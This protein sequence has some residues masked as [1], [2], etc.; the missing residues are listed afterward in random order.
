MTARRGVRGALG[1]LATAAALLF[2]GLPVRPAVVHGQAPVGHANRPAVA[3]GRHDKSALLSKLP[4]LPPQAVGAVLRRKM[5]PNRIGSDGATGDGALQAGAPA[6]AEVPTGLQ[7]FEGIGN[8]NA[9]LPPDTTGD[10]GL[11]HYVQMVNL[12][13]AMWDRNGTLV[14]GPVDIR[15]LWQG[16]GGPCQTRNDGDPIVQYDHLADRW[17][18]SQFALPN[19]PNGPFYQCIAV[20]ETGDPTGAYYRYE[21]QISNTKLNDY[22]KF[23]VWPDGYYMSI[24]QYT[25]NIVF[26]NWA[27]QGAVV[28]E[29]EAMLQGL[30]ARRVYFDLAGVD[31]NLGG[32]L[33]ADLDGPTLPAAGAANLFCQIDDNGWGYSGDQLQCWRF[34]T[35]WTNPLSST[36]TFDAAHPTAAFDADMCNYSR[37][38]IPQPGGTNVDAI[39]DRLMYRLQYRNFGTHETLVA[40]HTVDATGTDRGGVRW[41]ELRN[42]GGGWSIFQQ[43]TFSPDSHH[44]WMGSIAMNGLGDMALGY[45]V[46][47]AAVYPSIRVTGRLDGDAMSQMTQGELSLMNGT[48]YQTHSSGRWGDYSTMS[49]DPADDCMF[50]YTQEYYAATQLA[51]GWRTRIGAF[52]LRECGAADTPPTVTIEA[53]AAGATVSSAVAIEIAANDDQDASGTLTVQWNVDGGAWQT[54]TYNSTLNRYVASWNSTTVGDGSHTVNARATDSGSHTVT[55]ANAVTVDNVAEPPSTHVGDLDRSTT[56]QKSS[57]TAIVTITIRNQANAAVANATVTGSWSNGA[58]GTSSC[59]TNVSG[60]C[61]VIKAGIKNRTTSVSFTVTN[62]VHP[63][64]PYASAGNQDPDGD[65]NGTTISILKP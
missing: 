21:F 65:S 16:F 35:N 10:I 31:P 18:L 17:M 23:G 13:L 19:F 32:M 59:A 3:H 29:R 9:V 58:A 64:L 5:L 11:N 20:S 49:V 34:Q 7:N 12:S 26:C 52:K 4:Q 63:T 28:F 33:P 15:T 25:C 40:N 39:S 41:Y 8:V 45:S 1:I 47:S 48:G 37:N 36:F 54:A 57:W 42:S 6:G 60:Q 24:N 27:G 38:C 56:K 2:S 44:R 50:W 22:P 51:A 61:S 43:G 53:P 30:P 55:D 14:Y 62:V 46:S